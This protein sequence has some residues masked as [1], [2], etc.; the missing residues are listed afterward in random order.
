MKLHVLAVALGL[1][2]AR[3]ALAEPSTAT[4]SIARSPGAQRGDALTLKAV[5]ARARAASLGV[6]RAD[7][8]VRSARVRAE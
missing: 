2:L 3:P 4:S 6:H 7:A 5:V 1:S 8:S